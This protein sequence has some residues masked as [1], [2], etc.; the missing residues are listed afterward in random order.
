MSRRATR[1]NRSIAALCVLSSLW[2][3]PAAAAEAVNLRGWDHPGFSRLVFEWPR[4][5]EYQ[6]RI[7]GE[8]VVITFKAEGDLSL[9][10]IRG[11]GLSRMGAPTL[12]RENGQTVL[13]FKKK[14]E[15]GIHHYREGG[16]I[17]L[18]V[19]DAARTS[20][21]TPAPTPAP[22]ASSGGEDAF[23]MAQLEALREKSA[24]EAKARE[25]ARR[26]RAEAAAKPRQQLEAALDAASAENMTI[27][28]KVEPLPK[29][30]AIRYQFPAITPAA[31]FA[32]GDMLILAWAGEHTVTHSNLEKAT[33]DRVR[34]VQ[35]LS[36]GGTTVLRFR[37]RPGLG[38][39]FRRDGALWSLELKDQEILPREAIQLVRQRDP[40]AGVR[41]FAPVPEPGLPV[42]LTDPADN[43]PLILVPI[44]SASAGML[45]A[46]HYPG[47]TV[48]RS[49]QG[50]VV[51]PANKTVRAQRHSNGIAFIGLEAT[52]AELATRGYFTRDDGTVG[53]ARLIDLPEWAGDP[54]IPFAD[55][56]GDLLHA[57]SMAPAE[58][59]QEHRWALAQFYLGNGMAADALG[60]LE[61]MLQLEPDLK[62]APVF[63]AARGVARLQMHHLN[64]ALEDLGHPILDNEPEALLWRSLALEAAQRPEEAL[65]AYATGADVLQLYDAEQRARFRLAAVRADMAL[66]GGAIAKRD[67]EGLEKADYS[68][69][70]RAEAA[71]WRGV[72]A[73]KAGDRA[74]AAAEFTV[75]QSLGQRRINAM[76]ALAL[77]ED[78][79]ARKSISAQEAIDRLDRLRFAWRGDGFEL[80]LLERLGDLYLEVKDP[81]SALTALRQ[82][83]NY[84]K[85]SP[86]TR[87][88][89]DKMTDVFRKLYLEGGADEMPPAQALGLYY[90]FRDL[91][92]L[93]AEGD[94]MIRKLAERLVS[95]DL[96]DRAASL[97][98]HQVKY[99]L[100][101]V[102]QAVVAAR[103]AMIHLMNDAPDQAIGVLR[104]T[105]QRVMPDDVRME[106]NRVEARALLELDR[107]DEAE[108]IL[109]RD[110]SPEAKML[111][112]DAYW[113]IKDWPR[114]AE[115]LKAVMPAPSARLDQDG[116]KLVMRAAVTAAMRSDEAGLAAL[117]RNYGTAMKGDALGAA[118][119]IITAP[120]GRGA[121]N[122]GSLSDALADIDRIESFMKNYKA[123]FR[124]A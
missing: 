112:A 9:A 34:G 27:Q 15:G 50:L 103:L 80:S 87:A 88:L 57:L 82:A 61:R 74:T 8:D 53:R 79:L 60:V 37:I 21:S 20:A 48:L 32:R 71:Y 47:G 64:D 107:A 26:K 96:Y 38:V 14:A 119:D 28:G 90:D 109:E 62:N 105:R 30:V 102:P 69:E 121:A 49:V 101:G 11:F 54:R 100:E 91:T 84:F 59:Q 35:R 41:V 7:E 116:R 18:D 19:R 56:K 3:L 55:R 68:A 4:P 42:Q 43:K 33:E 95:V 36:V 78:E 2:V 106:R 108:A 113:K 16:K 86:R 65:M 51:K 98:E 115:A 70:V 5:V 93:G 45:E 89:A 10:R 104:A 75:A 1:L 44:S 52:S 67:L 46:R 120:D 111:L 94:T 118:F 66:G 29:G 76:A 85:P 124:G 73:A 31:A 114:H 97:L 40:V 117:R 39:G 17:V 83:V 58:E 110:T 92:P 12:S 123:A 24:A 122:L 81:R 25:E 13:R 72:L 77:T 23:V 99:R 6:A 63:R 22:A